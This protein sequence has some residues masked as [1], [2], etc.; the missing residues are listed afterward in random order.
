M[1]QLVFRFDDGG[2]EVFSLLEDRIG[3]GREADN[4]IV[5]D[6]D[7]ISGHH[8][9]FEREP[10]G[11][12]RLLD[13]GSQNGTFVNGEAIG[14]ALL[15]D[16]DRIGFGV[17]EVGYLDGAPRARSGP[18]A[19]DA[20]GGKSRLSE[21]GKRLEDLILSKREELD[22]VELRVA[23]LEDIARALEERLVPVVNPVALNAGDGGGSLIDEVERLEARHETIRRQLEERREQL[24]GIVD[25]ELPEA[26][27]KLAEA[28]GERDVLQAVWQE[29]R[30]QIR[31]AEAKKQQYDTLEEGYLALQ[32][33]V[34]ALEQ[35]R[36]LKKE[37]LELTAKDLTEAE[38]KL[39][40]ARRKE[41]GARR[42][43]DEAVRRRGIAEEES[44]EFG[45][46]VSD[47]TR[48]LQEGRNRLAAVRQ[49]IAGEEDRRRQVVL[50]L[51][52]TGR[53][54]RH[55]Q[56]RFRLAE[57][58][59]KGV[60]SG[61]NE[62]EKTRLGEIAGR[63]LELDEQYAASETRLRKAR[64][65]LQTVREQIELEKEGA[66]RSIE[67]L[68]AQQY[69]PAR[70]LHAELLLRSE[71]MAAELVSQERRLDQVRRTIRDGEEAEKLVADS[72]ERRGQALE[73]L[74][75]RI[76]E[77]V[78][79]IRAEFVSLQR[80]LT[81]EGAARVPDFGPIFRTREAA[82]PLPGRRSAPVVGERTGLVVY[83]PDHGERTSDFRH[84][85]ELKVDEEP[86]P[87]G[88]AGL[89]AATR[90]AVFSSLA[91]T[92]ESELPVL[93]PPAG[94]LAAS[95]ALLKKL[96]SVMP[97]RVILGG[98]TREVFEALTEELHAGTNFQD[99]I[100][101]LAMTNGSITT[102]P[103][104][105]TFF[106]SMNQGKRYL[107][108]PPVLPWN[109]RSQ[110]SFEGR[111]GLIVD[112]RSYDPEDLGQQ[113]ILGELRAWVEESR[114]VVTVNE[115]SRGVTRRFRELLGLGPDWVRVQNPG[116]YREWL[117][118]M[119]G[120]V[121]AVSFTAQTFASELLRD[122]LLSHTPVL[123]PASEVMT[124]FYP[125]LAEYAT[126]RMLPAAAAMRPLLEREAH[127]RVT[128]GADK[129]LLSE[130]SYQAAAR[131][132]DEF[133]GAL[134]R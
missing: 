27:A 12:Y 81:W 91:M 24:R 73:G 5:I 76:G 47:L 130:Y 45:A 61:W 128:R 10:G 129:R 42:E 74:E 36:L 21:E 86:L 119:R 72:L 19:V 16:G 3:V 109:P 117:D 104:M 102:D 70:Q 96:R 20:E 49:E 111:K 66:R 41:E 1:P 68:R 82:P 53:M 108:L 6:N 92:V 17:Y 23:Q 125:D 65:E 115:P 90:G 99:L 64:E 40:E 85:R 25:R 31:E 118:M 116:S 97:G 56:E 4:R 13:L 39:R 50:E 69:E 123:G 106:E 60:I 80:P 46:R 88:F 28:R 8:A 11:G 55:A 63:K 120:H 33:S 7:Y 71:T 62:F 113:Q 34:E 57:D 87:L 127:E 126:G 114:A 30:E 95:V 18:E 52:E 51:E 105:N 107:Y 14:E 26:E 54:V 98:W 48:E 132:L 15:K 124:A 35:E 59:V 112:L 84:Q 43:A 101:V 22:A 121:A 75:Q 38:E 77:E 32:A 78:A 79:Q 133:L 93:F 58:R 67:E 2:E 37:L 29:L 103:Y 83:Q 110:P 94:G 9:R 100:G 134:G 89:A 122:A 131:K 44:R